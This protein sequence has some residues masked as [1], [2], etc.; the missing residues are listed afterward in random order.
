RITWRY[1]GTDPSLR[2]VQVA[3]SALAIDISPEEYRAEH[4]RAV[5][6]PVEDKPPAGLLRIPQNI[7]IIVC[8]HNISGRTVRDSSAV[9]INLHA[10]EFGL[11]L[12]A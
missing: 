5:G 7:E 1:L 9:A 2:R 12:P 10:R 3:I 4:G 11:R 8:S 6:C